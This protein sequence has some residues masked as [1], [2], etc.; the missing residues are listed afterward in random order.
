MKIWGNGDVMKTVV[1]SQAA[2]KD[3]VATMAKLERLSSS[4]G[5]LRTIWLLN[6]Q[7]DV[8]S[9]LPTVQVPTLVVHRR[10]DARV[11]VALPHCSEDH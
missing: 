3:A 7:I 8:T 6:G 10:T 11:P 9:I 5:A 2:D 4:P 1:P